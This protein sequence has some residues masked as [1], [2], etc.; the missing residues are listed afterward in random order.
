MALIKVAEHTF[1]FNFIK[2][3]SCVVCTTKVKL[4]YQQGETPVP[5]YR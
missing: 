5:P 1:L 3:I 4:K 2:A